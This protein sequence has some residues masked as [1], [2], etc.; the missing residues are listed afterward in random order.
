MSKFGGNLKA[1]LPVGA[2]LGLWVALAEDF[3][4][5]TQSATLLYKFGDTSLVIV[6]GFLSNMAV[7]LAGTIL[8]SILLSILDI[9]GRYTPAKHAGRVIGVMLFILIFAAGVAYLRV[10]S[11]IRL[12]ADPRIIFPLL[13]VTAFSVIVG[14]ISS[15][16]IGSH[17]RPERWSATLGRHFSIICGV[18]FLIFGVMMVLF[19]TLNK[20]VHSRSVILPTTDNLLYYLIFIVGGIIIWLLVRL[21]VARIFKNRPVPLLGLMLLPAVIIFL[22]YLRPAPPDNPDKHNPNPSKTGHNVIFITVDTCRY[23]R[24]GC[25]FNNYMRTPTIDS[26]AAES[27]I[28]DN[29]VTPIPFTIPSHCSM[30]T[31]LTPREHGVRTQN[32]PLNDKFYTLAE[33]LSDKGYT[34]GAFVS[35]SLLGGWNSNLDQG[36]DYFDDFWVFKDESRFFPREIKFFYARR[37]ICKLLSGQSAAPT[38]HERRAEHTVDSALRWL[39]YVKDEDFFCFLHLFDAHWSYFAPEPY[40]DMYDPDYDG[41]YTWNLGMYQDRILSHM[42]KFD[43]ADFDHLVSRYDGEITYA[44]TQLGRFFDK[45]KELGLWDNSIIVLTADHGESFEHDYFF[46]HALRVYQANIHVPLIIKPPK[47]D[48]GRRAGAFC[49][50]M[51]IFP[52]ICELLDF[53][54]PQGIYGVSLKPFIDGVPEAADFVPHRYLLSESAEFGPLVQNAGKVYCII[55]DKMKL[56]FTPYGFPSVP[57]FQLYNLADDPDEKVNLY[58]TDKESFSLLFPRLEKWVEEDRPSAE[59]VNT[60]IGRETLRSLQYL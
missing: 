50:T 20:D 12:I 55:Q 59:S 23:D 17:Y 34:T 19:R 38:R 3:R 60:E 58:G 37:I 32:F 14:W 11:S 42:M 43:Q 49:S 6:Y 46:E 41:P 47:G 26:L 31:G 48:S 35:L 27:V 45:L 28:F 22:L 39:D 4:V 18:V 53:K 25:D 51:D 54:E 7:V 57:I 13:G 52:T 44:D 8:I 24:L 10:L 15:W 56:I 33:Y 2:C 36:F 1:A 21:L 16:F 5:I 29:C 30:F 9:R 40:R